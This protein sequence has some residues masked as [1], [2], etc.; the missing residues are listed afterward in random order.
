MSEPQT[1]S[2]IV[3]YDCCPTYVNKDTQASIITSKEFLH[4]FKI[5]SGLTT[6]IISFVKIMFFQLS[7]R[8]Q[9]SLPLQHM[10][11]LIHLSYHNGFPNPLSNIP[12]SMEF[13]LYG[14][15]RHMSRW[16]SVKFCLNVFYRCPSRFF[17]T[18]LEIKCPPPTVTFLSLLVGFYFYYHLNIYKL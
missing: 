9:W 1:I 15:T 2:L 18:I 5:Q 3:D 16:Y 13:S 12:K 4:T 17:L 8:V 11:L 6:A 14:T 10:I 7:S